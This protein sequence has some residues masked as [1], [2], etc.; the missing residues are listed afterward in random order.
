M[1]F[2]KIVYSFLFIDSIFVGC[3]SHAEVNVKNY[4]N[5]TGIPQENLNIK[6]NSVFS[7]IDSYEKYNFKYSVILDISDKS[8][9]E[10]LVV[11]N[12]AK[13]ILDVI[14][15]IVTGTCNGQWN[16]NANSPIWMSD[17]G[18]GKNGIDNIYFLPSEKLKKL[19]H[20]DKIEIGQ[21]VENINCQMDSY[22]KGDIRYL[23]D[24]GYFLYNLGYF[25]DSLRVLNKVIF[26]DPNRTVAYL[27]LADVYK[28]LKNENKAKENYLIYIDKMKKMGLDDK[29]PHRVKKYL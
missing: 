22:A 6:S 12:N 25:N 28:A 4:K 1:K 13:V 20:K 8:S 17:V 14:P 3:L 10:C 21:V 7:A 26:L 18:G 16:Q 19:S 11:N 24:S 9:T 2:K 5:C 29:I 27:N 15:S 23:N